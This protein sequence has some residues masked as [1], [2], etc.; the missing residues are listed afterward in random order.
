MSRD[1]IDDKHLTITG[2]HRHSRPPGVTVEDDVE[3]V[4]TQA[5]GPRGD[6]LVGISDVRF[7]G[8]PAITLLIRAD[9]REGLVHISPIHGDARKAGFTDIPVGTVCELACPVSGEPLPKVGD[10]EDGFDAAYYGLYLTKKLDPS[11]VAAI[12]NVWG[13]YRSRLITDDE[14]ISIWSASHPELASP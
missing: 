10:I 4:L 3:I 1:H 13:H 6:N 5:F 2:A 8:Y 12:S 9:G 14:L 11:Q 7:D